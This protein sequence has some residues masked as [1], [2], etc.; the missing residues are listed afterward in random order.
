MNRALLLPLVS[1]L[2]LKLQAYLGIQIT[3]SMVQ[4]ITDTLFSIVVIVGFFM[5]PKKQI[6]DNKDK[7]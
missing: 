2:M 6:G 3:D 5:N 4:M 7:E 1:F